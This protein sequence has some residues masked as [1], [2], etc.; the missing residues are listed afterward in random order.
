MMK[1]V[2]TYG[3]FDLLHDGHIQLLKEAAQLG[4]SLVVGLFTDEV[5][6]SFKRKP[7][8]SYEQRYKILSSLKVVTSVIPQKKLQ[9]NENIKKVLKDNFIDEYLSSRSLVVAKGPGAQYEDFFTDI[10]AATGVLC[11]L[12]PYHKGVSTSDI[13]NKIKGEDVDSL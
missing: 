10:N 2:Y 4:D 7:I 5:A 11:V 9:P 1:Y 13:I 6:E 8:M 3:V 12:L